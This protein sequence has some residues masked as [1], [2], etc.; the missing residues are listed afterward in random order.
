M[1]QKGEDK[2]LLGL[3]QQHDRV[4]W[5]VLWAPSSSLRMWLEPMNNFFPRLGSLSLASTTVEEMSLMVPELLQ[6]PDLRSLSLHGI[7]LPKGLSLLSSMT[8]LSTLSLTHIRHS[9]YFPPGSLVTQLQGLPRL[10]EL[11][12][13]LSI[14]IPPSSEG[15]LLPAPISPVT[16]PTLR[17]LTFHGDDI[18]LDNFVAQINTPLLEQLNLTLLFDLALTLVNLTAFID[19]TKGFRCLVAQVIFN[20][21]GASIDADHERGIEKLNLHV[22]CESLDWQI[23][24]AVQ[25]CKAL[26]KV[27]STIEELTIDLDMDGMPLFW[28]KTLDSMMWHELL[29]QFIGVKK[30]RIG[31]SLSVELSRALE[32]VTLELL[33]ELQELR[34]QPKI[35]HGTDLFSLFVKTRKS[36]GRPVHLVLLGRKRKG[37]VVCNSQTECY[38]LIL[39]GT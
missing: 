34:V 36:L 18:Y 35:N 1:A 6:V 31:S 8:A 3:Q 22:N 23:D 30:L 10:K 24:S 39:M 32:S 20:K 17:Q 13:D 16:L 33:P 2:I 5:I 12:I 19:R 11:S 27:F 15:E 4:R 26:E 14:P 21:G 9:C 37:L 25:L 29:L 7:G 28:E 38:M